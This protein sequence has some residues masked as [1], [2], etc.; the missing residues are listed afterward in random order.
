MA[1]ENGDIVKV[2][3]SAYVKSSGQ[4]ID[5]TDEKKAKDAGLFEEKK[6]YGPVVLNVG[7]GDVLKGVDEGLV[8][9][10]E[11]ES[12]ELEIQPEKA[13]GQRNEELV[14]IIPLSQFRKANIN[15]VPG[16]VINIDNMPASIRAVNSGRVV[17]DFN[18]PLAGAPLRYE[19]KMLKDAKTLQEKA[20]LLSEKYEMKCDVDV[21][22]DG[23]EVNLGSNKYDEKRARDSAAV[24]LLAKELKK[25]GAK[26]VSFKGEWEL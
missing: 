11:G 2:E 12:K 8:G 15:P 23:V 14:R 26:K 7:A 10:K 25:L 9:L 17:V 1:V 22:G 16:Q 6:K 19:I 4:L 18:H 3:Y 20:I 13:F 24:A 21:K 5:T